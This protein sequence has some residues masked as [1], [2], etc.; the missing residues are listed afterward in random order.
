MLQPQHQ[1]PQSMTLFEKRIFADIIGQIMMK[2]LGSTLIQYNWGP[3]KKGNLDIET[4]IQGESYVKIKVG[5]L[6]QARER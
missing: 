5:M 6:L 3:Y 2:S 4:S 1:V